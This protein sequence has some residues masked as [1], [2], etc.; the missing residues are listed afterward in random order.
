MDP[1]GNV[2]A[3]VDTRIPEIAGNPVPVLDQNWP[4]SFYHNELGSPSH[5]WNQQYLGQV[6]GLCVDDAPNKNIYVAATTLYGLFPAGPG[7]MGAVYK[8][9]GTSGNICVF[10]QLPNGGPGLGNLAYD[11]V[12]QHIFASN[13][14]DGLIYSLDTNAGCG[15]QQWVTYDHGVAGRNAASLSPINDAGTSNSFTDLGRRVWGVCVEGDRLY[16]SVWWEDQSQVNGT[17]QNQ[18]WSVQITAAGGFTPG[19]AILEATIPTFPGYAGS[20]PIADI[21]FTNSGAML[22]AERTIPGN[23][24]LLHLGNNTAHAS[25]VLKFTGSSGSFVML[26][27]STYKVGSYYNG[28]NAAGGVTSDCD[29]N[30]WASGD[31][32]HFIGA[33]PHPD[34]LYG[35]TRINA[36][37]NSAD[38]PYT[39]NT[40]L[41][42][43]GNPAYSGGYAK[44]QLGE[45]DYIRDCPP[46]TDCPNQTSTFCTGGNQDNY[47]L[48]DGPE[49]ATPSA[50]LLASVMCA[51]GALTTFD[52]PAVRQ[53][54]VHTLTEC[55]QPPAD[56][57][58]LLGLHLN[59]GLHA[60]DSA[61]G[62]PLNNDF[63]SLGQGGVSMWQAPI[64]NLTTSGQWQNGNW[65]PGQSGVYSLDLSALPTAN[66]TFNL[67]DLL[68]GCELDIMVAQYTAV[69]FVTVELVWCCDSVG[70]GEGAL[71][72]E[73]SD[74]GE[75]PCMEITNGVA[76]CVSDDSGTGV[77]YTFDVTNLSGI[78]AA[79]VLV[80]PQNPGVTVTPNVIPTVLPNGGTGGYAVTINGAQP[81]E[82]ICITITLQDKQ[83]KECCSETICF[84]NPCNCVLV[85]KETL[86]CKDDGT[87]T[88][89]FVITNLSA[90]TIEHMYLF[91]DT[92][93]G[94]TFTPNY[95][96]VPTLLPGQTSGLIT[97]NIAGVAP[98]EEFCYTLSV[99]DRRLDECCFFSRCITLPDCCTDDTEPPVIKCLENIVVDC[100][101]PFQFE[102]AAVDNCDGESVASIKIQGNFDTNTPGVQCVVV[103]ATDSSG[104]SSVA[105]CCITVLNNCDPANP[106]AKHAADYDGDE[107]IS[108]SEMLRVVQFFNIG[109]LH[110]DESTED[111]YAPGPGSLMGAPHSS[112]YINQDWEIGLDELLRLVQMYNVGAYEPCP[113][114]EDGFCPVE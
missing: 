9:D 14:E 84:E 107:A 12:S 1:N 41:I 87:Y 67:T 23:T 46:V 92:P 85:E 75:G 53:C 18:I 106:V 15:V 56:N 43:L 8:I 65:M 40:Y 54:F 13:H 36:A 69:D 32:L 47:A 112:D 19:S 37:G 11:P 86:T 33:T 34:V 73:G 38:V 105:D 110:C 22:A 52:T 60:G 71:E 63:I 35:L 17:E 68:Q 5:K 58:E 78:D 26:P 31:A 24:G 101:A 45:V 25:R 57:C 74:E 91:P 83:H 108:I 61:Q 20:A 96:D 103:V 16:Y 21:E 48:T 44:T 70:E 3:L 62:L 42:S 27:D 30:V 55:C 97:V 4:V 88:Y 102:V 113:V 93:V 79:W 7:G 66:G 81:G 76:E 64:S 100:G 98:G 49:N 39:L 90:F 50:A 28:T 114:G 94:A 51:G 6:F 80:T 111:G 72:G 29:E 2:V 104:N 10:A 59:I 99:H 77:S 109:E 95:V 89:S 82:E